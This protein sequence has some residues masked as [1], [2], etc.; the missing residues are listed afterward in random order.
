MR[1][2]GA[3]VLLTA[4]LAFS[5]AAQA[6]P[7]RPRGWVSD[8]AG[9]LGDPGELTRLIESVEK[10]TSVEIS[11]VTVASLDGLTI[12]D[13]SIKLAEKWEVGKKGRDNGVLILVAP[14]EREVRIEV[15]YG[16]EAT[17]TDGVC[18]G[19][20]REVLMPA[21]KRG[22]YAGGLRDAVARIAAHTGG[23]AAEMPSSGAAGSRQGAP[24]TNVAGALALAAV[25]AFLA[26]LGAGHASRGRRW[27]W[28]LGGAA[29]SG[30]LGVAGTSGL[31][32]GQ[33]DGA[34]KVSLALA[35]VGWVASGAKVGGPGRGGTTWLG[36]GFGG[37]GGGGGFG[38]F[39]GGS[40]GGGG[41]SGRW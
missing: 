26:G 13:F 24:W 41:A 33:T 5:G 10:R 2:S 3:A 35:C 14:K 39:G 16:L 1:T 34:V 23:G 11:V 28:W 4:A 31:D 37:G 19:I 12:E 22:N 21:F 25:A 6:V 30:W 29:A 36:G 8:F 18:G 38:G 27:G 15:G 32:S 40:F 9:V 7:D 17:L 20:I